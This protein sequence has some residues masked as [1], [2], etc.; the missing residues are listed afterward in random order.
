[1]TIAQLI[2]FYEE[3]RI[4][5]HELI[6]SIFDQSELGDIGVLLE[7]LPEHPRKELNRYI[8]SFR[9]GETRSTK[10]PISARHE[11]NVSAVKDWLKSNKPLRVGSL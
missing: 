5:S 3:G 6:P 10:G 11:E 9:P 2:Q 4:T 8:D 1:M 7:A